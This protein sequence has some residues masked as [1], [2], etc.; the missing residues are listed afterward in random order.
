MSP[1]E[2]R[3]AGE[4]AALGDGNAAREMRAAE[5]G[6]EQ[7]RNWVVTNGNR[8]GGEYQS[9][10]RAAMIMNNLDKLYGL[11]NVDTL[12]QSSLGSAFREQVKL[13]QTD[14]ELQLMETTLN[15]SIRQFNLELDTNWYDLGLKWAQLDWAAKLQLLT[16]IAE[17]QIVEDE[18][19]VDALKYIAE[20]YKATSDM[21]APVISG[22]AE[23]SIEAGTAAGAQREV[24]KFMA[25]MR[26]DPMIKGL[27]ASLSA[28]LAPLTPG[29]VFE[30]ED[31]SMTQFGVLERL[32]NVD[33]RAGNNILTTAGTI[34]YPEQ[35]PRQTEETEEEER[36]EEEIEIE[37]KIREGL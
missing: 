1:D 32:L 37:R 25:G 18:A 15:E 6:V 22:V 28:T 21:L 26:T 9:A 24:A 33:I 29:G 8:L 12:M 31:F 19:E 4:R 27:L 17:S 14:R 13:S 16:L 10:E 2:Y 36:S 7:V 23:V 30:V 5:M 34:R 35:G 20:A 11:D 3:K